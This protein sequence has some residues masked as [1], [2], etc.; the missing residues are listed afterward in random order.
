M[1]PLCLEYAT[2]SAASNAGNP[3]SWRFFS[4]AQFGIMWGFFFRFEATGW[5]RLRAKISVFVP[6]LKPAQMQDSR[7]QMNWARTNAGLTL[8]NG[9]SAP[10]SAVSTHNYAPIVGR[11]LQT[12]GLSIEVHFQKKKKKRVYIS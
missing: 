6:V 9:H 1:H 3:C 4:F 12:R 11:I 8:T 5:L 10:D 2:V 7:A